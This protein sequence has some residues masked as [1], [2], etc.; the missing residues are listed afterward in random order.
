[1]HLVGIK[2][3]LFSEVGFRFNGLKL[4]YLIKQQNVNIV[5][6]YLITNDHMNFMLMSNIWDNKALIINHFLFYRI[7]S[8]LYSFRL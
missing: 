5:L 6:S 8:V 4:C 2:R 1:M 3:F 7:R